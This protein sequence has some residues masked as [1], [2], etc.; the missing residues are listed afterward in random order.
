MQTMS[1]TSGLRSPAHGRKKKLYALFRVY[2]LESGKIGVKLFL[3]PEGARKQGLLEFEA[4]GWT[5][6]A[7]GGAGR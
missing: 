3:D 5:V 6:T 2:G 1:D 7:R 4:E